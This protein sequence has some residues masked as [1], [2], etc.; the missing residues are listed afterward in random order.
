M[1]L[2]PTTYGFISAC[3]ICLSNLVSFRVNTDHK[4]RW[5]FMILMLAQWDWALVYHMLLEILEFCYSALQGVCTTISWLSC[6]NFEHTLAHIAVFPLEKYLP[7]RIAWVLVPLEGV[8]KIGFLRCLKPAWFHSW[9]TGGLLVHWCAS[10][11]NFGF[12]NLR[13]S[14]FEM[15]CLSWERWCLKLVCENLFLNLVKLSCGF[16]WQLKLS[17]SFLDHLGHAW[18]PVLDASWILVGLEHLP[19]FK[20]LDLK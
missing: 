8:L 19:W 15:R 20:Q 4:T 6:A 18:G 14:C 7:T 11:P 12:K 13:P 2:V 1:K 9:W 17:C 16:M 3:M 5:V 10:W